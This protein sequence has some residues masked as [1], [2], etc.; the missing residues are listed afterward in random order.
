M[1]SYLCVRASEAV[2]VDGDI[3]KPVWQGAAWTEDF[4]DIEGE[5]MP[6]PTWRTRVKMLWDDTALYIAAELEEPHVW[7]TLAGRDS[8]IFH[9]NDFEVFLDPDADNQH[10]VELEL[11]AFNTVWDLLLPKPYKD[12][13]MPLTGWRIRGL[14]TAV[15][16]QG[17]LN[18]PTDIDNGWTV[19]ISIPWLALEEVCRCDC[20]PKAGDQWRINFSRVQWDVEVVHGTYRKVPDRPEHNWVWSPQ[21]VIDMHRPERWG[22]LQFAD[23]VADVLKH[24]PSLDVRDLLH[25]AYYSHKGGKALPEGVELFTTPSTFEL[26]AQATYPDRSVHEWHLTSDGRIWESS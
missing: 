1:R 4:I 17:T 5:H 6:S 14:R 11:N 20:P 18:D 22:I 16:V 15:K 12:K 8:V 23:S 25:E 13:G 19:E 21:R 24:D 2:S 26:V 9:D 3:T 10:Y 7:A